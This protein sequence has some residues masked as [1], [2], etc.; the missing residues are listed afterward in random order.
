M[1]KVLIAA[2]M[3][4]GS[5]LPATAQQAA[6]TTPLN[7]AG[8]GFYEQVGISWGFR[9]GN[10]FFMQN[11]SGQATPPFGGFT[12]GAGAN[13]G[14][15]W[16]GGGASGF[17][18]LT[19]SQG[20]RQGL[21]AQAVTG[22]MLNGATSNFGDLSLMPFVVS[23]GPLAGAAPVS[24]I[25]ERL[26]RLN[27]EGGTA[28]TAGAPQAAQAFP[29]AAGDQAAHRL[30]AAQVGPPA[31]GRSVDEIKA[32]RA[33]AEQAQQAALDT[34]VAALVA[35]A[36]Q[37]EAAGKPAVAKIYYQQAARRKGGSP[38]AAGVRP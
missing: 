33:A 14:W 2:M 21:G 18:N 27:E 16:Q 32:A 4:L 34:E 17:F 5:A 25:Q 6:V 12:P 28:S 30:A 38:T 9:T 3:V 20:S 24:P 22:N 37:A 26:R 19:A 31:T 36:K 8:G 11:G 10:F 15:N 35:R 13:V 7:R 29:A 1:M 23:Q